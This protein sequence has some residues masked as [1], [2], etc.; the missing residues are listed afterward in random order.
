[1]ILLRDLGQVEACF[2]LLG[3]NVN[4]NTR[5]VLDMPRMY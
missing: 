3:D 2:H 1:M 5:W 4:L